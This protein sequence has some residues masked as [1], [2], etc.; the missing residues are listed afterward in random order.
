MDTGI[1]ELG[2][3]LLFFSLFRKPRL[4]CCMRPAVSGSHLVLLV[5]IGCGIWPYVSIRRQKRYARYSHNEKGL[6]SID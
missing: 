2:E 1:G 3:S 5:L 6:L 4:G